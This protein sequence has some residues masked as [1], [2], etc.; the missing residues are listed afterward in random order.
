[1]SRSSDP[2]LGVHLAEHVRPAQYGVVGYAMMSSPVLRVGIERLVRYLRL[3][4][5]AAT[6]SLQEV[7]Q[8]AKV[9]LELARGVREIP[10]QRVEY[11]L[12]TLFSL[13]RWVTGGS[14]RAIEATFQAPQPVDATDF[15]GMLRC[16]ITFGADSNS[17]TLSHADLDAALPTAMP[18]L[19]TFHE[20]IAR[21]GL[22]RLRNSEFEVRVHAAVQARLQDGRPLR[23][24]IAA[25]LGTSDRT[26]QR[27][28]LERGTSFEAMVES[29]R[30][31]LAEQYLLERT[32]SAMQIAF[33][34]GYADERSFARACVRWFGVPPGRFSERVA[35]A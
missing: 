25:D 6:I 18:S 9:S 14:L 27:R 35:E 1:M 31:E 21:T 24:Q 3:V 12:L 33:M 17:F 26:F 16:P 2:A 13:C 19:E 10:R 29:T 15:T 23:A 7:P 8:G 5:D 20:R 30:K 4:S 11:A 34:L 32:V 28:L 22:S